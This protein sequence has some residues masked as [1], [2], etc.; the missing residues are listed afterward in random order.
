[1]IAITA[2]CIP[3]PNPEPPIPL[4]NTAISLDELGKKM[5]SINF[6]NFAAF[7]TTIAAD[8]VDHAKLKAEF[9]R[10]EASSKTGVGTFSQANLPINKPKNR[11]VPYKIRFHDQKHETSEL[12]KAYYAGIT[13]S[14][15]TTTPE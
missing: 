15:P 8:P 6:D 4:A 3:A 2:F 14:F 1:M 5:K 9:K 12:H 7:M 13:T 11:Q 10:I